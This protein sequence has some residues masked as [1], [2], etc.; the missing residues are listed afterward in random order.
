MSVEAPLLRVRDLVVEYRQHRS[1]PVRALDGVSLEVATGE[2]LGLVGESGSGK[3]TLGRAI[4][5]LAPILSGTVELAGRDITHAGTRQRREVSR[6]LQV[7]FQ[8]PYSSLNPSRTIGQTLAE[9]LLV[10]ERLSRAE[11]A[12]R[13]RQALRRV[14]LPADTAGRYPSNFSG[15]Q[16][17]RIAIARALILSPTLIICDEPVSSLDLSIQAQVLNLLADLQ[18]ELSLSYLFISH[19]LAVVR[20]TT[21]RVV[22]MY[23]GRIMEEGPAAIVCSAPAHPYTQALLASVPVPDPEL[24]RAARARRVRVAASSV[25]FGTDT[26]GCPFAARCPYAIEQCLGEVPPLDR[27]PNGN[28]AACIRLPEVAST[29]SI[30]ST[31]VGVGASNGRIP[32][33]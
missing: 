6:Q 9:P 32:H 30:N 13:V 19:D 16:R 23:R 24:Q 3:S 8:D 25:A 27:A 31:A 5:G 28:L 15:G 20:H 17:Q 22:V 7:V 10:H 21:K 18:T 12:T 14:G 1:P 4:L 11:T 26:G 2:T 33:P 29:S